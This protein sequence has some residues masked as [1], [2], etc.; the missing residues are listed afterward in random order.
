MNELTV[1]LQAGYKDLRD[2]VS[3]ESDR[4]CAERIAICEF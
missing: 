2:E 1:L 3:L 4:S